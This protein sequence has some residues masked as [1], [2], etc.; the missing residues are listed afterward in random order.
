MAP[1][2]RRTETAAAPLQKPQVACF[3]GILFYFI[4]IL[5]SLITNIIFTSRL[6]SSLKMKSDTY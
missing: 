5:F 4:T 2:H 3:G 1:H 6:L